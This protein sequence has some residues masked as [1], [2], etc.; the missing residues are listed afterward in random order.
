MC[1]IILSILIILKRST[2]QN[3]VYISVLVPCFYILGGRVWWGLDYT[4][5]LLVLSRF[6]FASYAT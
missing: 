6:F 2:V 1:A 4:E 3:I 5:I